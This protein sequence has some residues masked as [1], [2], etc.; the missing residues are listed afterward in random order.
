MVITTDKSCTLPSNTALLAGVPFV[1]YAYTG[2]ASDGADPGLDRTREGYVEMIEMS[3]FP[4]YTCTYQ[5][6][7]HQRHAE[8]LRGD[9]RCPG[10]V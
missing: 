10:G 4:T 3:T 6:H 5:N 2:S 7:A 9:Q 8:G 1:N